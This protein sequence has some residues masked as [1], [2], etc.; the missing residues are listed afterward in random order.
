MHFSASSSSSSSTFTLHDDDGISSSDETTALLSEVDQ[1]LV[2]GQIPKPPKKTPVPKAQLMAVCLLRFVDTICTTLPFPYINEM[3]VR[4]DILEDPSKVGFV[5]GLVESG[6]SLL[7]FASIYPWARASNVFGRRP[8]LLLGSAGIGLMAFLFGFSRNLAEMLFTRSL[9]GFFAGVIAVTQ[10]FLGEISD[11]TNKAIIVPAWSFC[12]PFGTIVG[13]MIGGTFSNPADKFSFLDTPILRQY[14]YA[15]P[16]L[17]AAICS[18]LGVAFSYFFMK[19]TL[20]PEAK[21]ASK[22][23]GETTSYGSIVAPAPAEAPLSAGQL[24]RV[25]ALQSLI[26]SGFALS[27]ISFGYDTLFL[28]FAYTPVQVGGLG[29]NA[30][31]IAYCLS[32]TASFYCFAQLAIAPILLSKYDTAKLYH[33]CMS[34][35]VLPYLILPLLNLTLWAGMDESGQISFQARAMVWTGIVLGMVISRVAYLPFSFGIIL[36]KEGAPNQ[37]SLGPTNG[38]VQM[39][40]A[41]GKVLSP[42]IANS[43]FA[44]SVESRVFGGYLWVLVLAGIACLVPLSSARVVREISRKY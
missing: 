16:G 27:F 31:Q 2:E 43:T 19:E 7:Q 23:S 4:L 36:A 29:F 32:I 18:L 25:P 1:D 40:M 13:P 9:L 30:S 35:W 10:S 34:L 20:L 41:F 37:A 21:E 38:L 11:S 5:S 8:V 3:V 12:L 14:P 28:L 22:H 17:V 24:I 39:A 6:M 33:V 42:A 15:L 44:A 26:I